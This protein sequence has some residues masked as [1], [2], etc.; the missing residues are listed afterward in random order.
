MISLLTDPQ[1]LQAVEEYELLKRGSLLEGSFLAKIAGDTAITM[2]IAGLSCY[3]ELYLR[4]Q[5]NV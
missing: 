2:T 1:L 3:R 4:S 5:R